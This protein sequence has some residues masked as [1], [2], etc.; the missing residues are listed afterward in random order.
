VVLCKTE[1][2]KEIQKEKRMKLLLFDIDGTLV[3]TAGVGRRSME[4]SFEKIYGVKNGFHNIEMMGRTD[5]S[6][7]KEALFA[8]GLKWKEEDVGRFQETY[9]R[10]LNAEIQIPNPERRL[11]PGIFELLSLL[12][13][14]QNMVL[15]LLTGN[16]R[17]SA[18]IKLRHFQIDGYFTQ[19]AFADDS[20]Q[21]EDLVPIAVERIEQK[22]NVTIPKQ[23]V[24]V[25]G[26]TPSDIRC[27]KIYGVCS[28]AVAT[29]FH[30]LEELAKGKPD[31]LFEDFEDWERVVKIFAS[32]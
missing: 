21:R 16:W 23:N 20:E 29:G 19:G 2:K 5:P 24:Y 17:R 28:I 12:R 1:R 10:I 31:V 18:F 4:R 8:H 27:A 26:D 6:I 30:S 9:F 14:R 25:I 11:C 22:I 3:R 7:L 32:E 13:Q 15:S